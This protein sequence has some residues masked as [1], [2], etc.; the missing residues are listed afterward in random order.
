MRYLIGIDLGTTNCCVSYVD[1]EDAR[2]TTR[3]FSLPQLVGP[4]QVESKPLLPSFC[5]LAGQEEW[6]KGS[7]TLPWAS[8][9]DYMVGI[10]ALSYGSR[11]PTRLVSS[12]KS[13][14]CHSSVARNDPM[15]PPGGDPS[16]RISPV[17]A[18]SRYLR[19][20][21]EAWNATVAK[22][23]PEDEFEQQQIVITVP[24]SFDEVARALTVESAK[25][26]G[27]ASVSMLEEPQAAF[28]NWIDQNEKKWSE[29]LEAGS[30]ILVCDVGGG[31]T[32]FSF[33][34]V[35]EVNDKLSFLRMAV[36][37]HLL[38]G[39]ENIDN[40]LAQFIADKLS[41][42]L[43]PAQ[44][45]HLCHQARLAKETL[46]G[47][48]ADS[49]R[50]V[51]T[52]EGSKVVGG[53]QTYTI[54]REEA[55]NIVLEGFFGYLPWGEAIVKSKNSGFKSLGLPYEQE[56]SIIKHL[57]QFLERHQCVG[58]NSP[59][60]IL[61]NGG[62]MYPKI[63]QDA[64]IA[65]LNNWFPHQ[66]ITL[67]TAHHFDH[68]VSRG[69]AY[70]GKVK[71]GLGIRIGGGSPRTYYLGI[72]VKEGDQALKRVLTLLPRGSEEDTSYTS[73]KAFLATPNQP[74]AFQL[75]TSH[76]RLDD[77]KGDV[78]PLI[79]GEFHPLPPIHTILRYGKGSE[80]TQPI[81]VKLGIHL[82]SIGT[83]EVWL[84]SIKTSHKWNLEFQL[85]SVSGQDNSIQTL[86]K[87]RRDETFNTEY[88][89]EAIQILQQTFAGSEEFTPKNLMEK[90]E[91]TIGL[92]RKDWPLSILR[93]LWS[94]LLSVSAQRVNSQLLNER[95]WNLAG[96][97]LRPGKGYPLDD[98]RLKDLWKI[99]LGELK[100][101]N[102]P[103][104]LQQ[105]LICYRRI[106]AGLNRG[107]QL[108]IAGLILPNILTSKGLVLGKPAYLYQERLRAVGSMELIE[109]ST[110]V[111]IGQAL[112]DKI[113][114]GEADRVEFWALSKIAARQQLQG[115]L[116]HIVPSAQ[117]VAWVEKLL[118]YSSKI[119]QDKLRALI[120]PIAR[121][122]GHRE[123]DLP[124]ALRQTLTGFLEEP[125]K[126]ILL[127][128]IPLS[129]AEQEESFGEALPHGLQLS[130][131]E[132]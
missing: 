92:Q 102:P 82:T 132:S 21:A 72:D 73:E 121:L 61:F 128:V 70:F 98:F 124:L 50:I 60:H 58:E 24:A 47:A 120:I 112:V 81:E 64:V 4:G 44:W 113:I 84:Q 79:E 15:L 65:A 20:I 8:Q 13:W 10:F 55:D 89:S 22:D 86:G 32:D 17:E 29:I 90:L 106:A 100:K 19:H 105:Q 33:I 9:R 57:A 62:T 76:V 93:G 46:Y 43:T 85:R 26:A 130:M 16:L 5:Y 108:Q 66:K 28:Y 129:E 71:H 7:L 1:K 25:K 80:G 117:T 119:N 126:K 94:P 27:F 75:Y 109:I 51:L 88:L 77:S 78:I 123:V 110:K 14:L 23:K 30:R 97:L 59:T 52:G 68:A 101:N 34:K 67:L 41:K 39:G 18:S 104:V 131:Q 69:A 12:A 74:V 36:G 45:Q 122:T 11:V 83:L 40:A 118:K 63:F 127:E 125:Q 103:E 91:K 35:Q 107:Q 37:D 111:K 38:L 116:S 115:T 42:E 3:S 56:P 48:E 99:I 49:Y 6:D 2:A 31:T 54:T 95:W 114:Q 96:F 53:T 87:A